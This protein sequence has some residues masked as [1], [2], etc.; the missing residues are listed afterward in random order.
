MKLSQQMPKPTDKQIS[1]LE[2]LG[3][4]RS[5]LESLDRKQASNMISELLRK[6]VV[7]RQNEKEPFKQAYDWQQ[8][9]IET[10]RF[11]DRELGSD[12]F[13]GVVIAELLRQRFELWKIKRTS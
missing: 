8:A 7:Q 3:A 6:K 10:K 9:T 11:V 13:N 2:S 12:A 5:K 4:D 1:T